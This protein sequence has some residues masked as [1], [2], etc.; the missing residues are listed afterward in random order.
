MTILYFVR[1]AQPDYRFGVNSTFPLS[2]EGQ[3]DC[4]R[5][6]AF[7]SD[8]AFDVAVSSPYRRSVQTIEPI[9]RKQKLQLHT[10]MRLRER[11][12]PG[13][14]SNSNEMFKKRWADLSFHE[15]G[16]ES[17]AATQERNMAAVRDILREYNG[18][19]VL[20]GTHGTAFSTIMRYYCPDYG[21]ED[22]IRIINFMPYIVRMDFDN[23]SLL[24]IEELFYIE[25]PF[26][27]VRNKP[28][29]NKTEE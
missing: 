13:G 28:E 17:L 23:E 11:D 21:Y 15:E 25:K 20:V 18:Q 2:E 10:D 16:G 24:K 29:D 7:L 1:H 9:I 8:V 22:F 26:H 27:G 4:L 12:H 5:A 3:Q 19:T 6:A 14:N